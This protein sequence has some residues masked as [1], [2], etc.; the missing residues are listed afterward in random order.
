[1][2]K[3]KNIKLFESFEPVNESEDSW[4]TAAESLW[5]QFNIIFALFDEGYLNADGSPK[6]EIENINTHIREEWGEGLA[7]EGRDFKD[8]NEL[9]DWY[10][11]VSEEAA[12][13][14]AK[15]KF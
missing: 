15:Y 9:Y 6:T 11:K 4:G 13:F 5:N 1:M 3:P 10:N 8:E 7:G 14:G 2:K 12:A